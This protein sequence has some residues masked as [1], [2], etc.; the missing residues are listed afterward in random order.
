MQWIT[1]PQPLLEGGGKVHLYVGL[2]VLASL[3]WSGAHGFSVASFDN[4]AAEDRDM[5]LLNPGL[6]TGDQYVTL[7]KRRFPWKRLP[8]EMCFR[9]PCERNRE[10]CYRWNICDKSAKVCVDCWY[11]STC[12]SEQD[13]CSRYPYCARVWKK[14]KD[15][16][17]YVASG[18]C[19][20][21]L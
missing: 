20:R 10:C 21:K 18:K 12:R 6:S 9:E 8:H 17:R 19:V 16:S 2:V 5:E 14:S 4:S 1:V 13:C 3:A 15:G 7:L 11:G